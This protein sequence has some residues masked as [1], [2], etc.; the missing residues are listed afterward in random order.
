[1]SLHIVT[2][3][4]IFTSLTQNVLSEDKS[5]SSYIQDLGYPA[6][7]HEVTTQDGYVLTLHRI[8][9]SPKTKNSTKSSPI[10]FV[11]GIGVS[12]SLFIVPIPSV[13]KGIAYMLS[14]AGYDIWILHSR[15]THL[16]MRH[17]KHPPH[18]KKFWDFSW[19]EIGLFDV[20]TSIDYILRTTRRKKIH[21]V[22]LSQGSTAFLVALSQRP[23]YNRKVASSYLLVP[24]GSLV[25]VAGFAKFMI[26]SRIADRLVKT[27]GD[28]NL[29]Y[30]PLKNDFLKQT[31]KIFCQD[32]VRFTL[33]QELIEFSIGRFNA[34]LDVY[35]LLFTFVEMVDNVGAKQFQHYIQVKRSA[36]FQLYD[37]GKTRNQ[38]IYKTKTPPL[39]NLTNIAVPV[40]LVSGKFDNL[41]SEKDVLILKSKLAN[42]RHLNFEAN[43]IDF[44]GVSGILNEIKD[45]MIQFMRRNE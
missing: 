9:K 40:T 30:L 28:A 41:A 35:E 27:F 3:I 29:H 38:Q 34:S 2:A 1:M 43:H 23:D 14:D 12:G 5:L 31:L 25:H 26:E 13:D 32:R 20:T 4:V 22:G 18:S 8:P 7:V 44:L 10:L 42:V 17:I 33:C 15:G 36:R 16:S 6:E 45:D 24:V 21:Y 37:N 39:Y 19:H 11:H